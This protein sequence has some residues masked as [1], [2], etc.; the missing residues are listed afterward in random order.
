MSKWTCLHLDIL[1]NYDLQ[2][3]SVFSLA[4]AYTLFPN[5]PVNFRIIY[6]NP[7][8]KIG[9]FRNEEKSFHFKSLENNSLNLGLLFRL[10]TLK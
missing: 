10:S 3:F 7:L 5:Y 1:A 4:Y 6:R 8:V 2:I 9:F